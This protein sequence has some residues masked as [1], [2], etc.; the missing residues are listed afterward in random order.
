MNKFKRFDWRPA[1]GLLGVVLA[2]AILAVLFN[3][4][5]LWLSSGGV[6]MAMALNATNCDP[7]LIM[8]DDAMSLTRA[9]ITGWSKTDI[10]NNYFK[11][12]GLDRIIAQTKEARMAGARQRT[13]GDLI[14]SRYS[15]LSSRKAQ[16]YPR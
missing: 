15:T 11:E 12:V 13:L 4:L 2:V 10:E 9:N 16:P 6:S 5:M 8:V 7:R 1:L 3:D 14:R